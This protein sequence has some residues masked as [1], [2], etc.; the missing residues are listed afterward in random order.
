MDLADHCGLGASGTL[1]YSLFRVG[2][3]EQE[4]WF[5]RRARK[6][7]FIPKFSVAMMRFLEEKIRS[8]SFC[9]RIRSIF[10]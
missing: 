6:S 5:Y 7:T 8:N 4:V 2:R 9:P 10:L 1:D 3:S